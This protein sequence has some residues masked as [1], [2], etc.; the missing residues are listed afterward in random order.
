MSW[1]DSIYSDGT[2]LFVNNPEPKIGE[3]VT[4]KLR[5][6]R[7]IHPEAVY[8]RII[9]NGEPLPMRCNL[10]KEDSLFAWYEASFEITQYR[11]Q[12]QFYIVVNDVF[13]YYNQKGI[14]TCVP[15]RIHDFVLLADYRQP[16]WVKHSV[17]YQIFPD[18]FYNGNPDNDVRDGEYQVNGYDTIQVK[19]WDT[20]AAEYD[21]V[22]CADFYGGD[23]EGIQKKIPYLKD[24]GV[25]AIYLNP[26]FLA[27]SVHKYDC[28]DYL[29]VDP[30]LGGDEALASLS[31]ALHEQGMKLILD[32]SINHTGTAHRWFN[33]DC[34]FFSHDVGAYHNPDC[35]ERSYY[36]IHEDNSYEAWDNV[37]ELPKLNFSSPELRDTLYRAEDS[38]IK[39]WL[40]PP[41]SID[42]WR[43]DVADCMA[44]FN[45]KQ[46]AGEVWPQIRAAIKEVNPQAYLLAENWDDCCEYLQG[47]CWDAP[48]NYYGFGRIIRQFYQTPDPYV[49]R[50]PLLTRISA[51]I[52]AE[53]FKERVTEYL[54]RIPFVLWQNQYNL[55]G[56]HDTGRFHCYPG[57]NVEKYRGAVIALLTMI[58][59]ASIYYGDEASIGGRTGFFEGG[60]YPMP[61]GSNFEQTEVY[62]LYRTLAHL[63]Q[64]HSVFAEGSF[65]FLYAVG[66]IVAFARFNEEECFVTVLSSSGKE[67]NIRLPLTVCGVIPE[68]GVP[69]EDVLRRT[70][71]CCWM[72]DE[73]E[74]TVPSE[75][76]YLLHFKVN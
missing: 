16:K 38:V 20:P 57:M 4:V 43:F 11:M 53:D 45:E 2:E 14:T 36:Y 75:N 10:E 58:G 51:G 15:D 67:E 27:P 18:R 19:E 74:I 17:F 71:K 49:E 33:R 68:T 70:I 44:N 25:T 56:S 76:A 35:A 39:K 73:L 21:E 54:S 8:V 42:G 41:Y 46:L 32:I 64:E 5:I 12:Y 69:C 26:I 6:F 24:L 55:F 7:D 48:M 63:R 50:D 28:I 37:P 40:K 13:Y 30:H 60:R 31:R 1:I 23:L 34:L 72:K 29:H 9:R 59:T 62:Q 3:K 66:S 52:S 47:N 65:R 61:W 22:H